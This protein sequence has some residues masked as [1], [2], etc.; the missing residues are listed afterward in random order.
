MALEEL[1]DSKDS[2]IPEVER[3]YNA[4]VHA[5]T[6]SERRQIICGLNVELQCGLCGCDQTK[7]NSMIRLKSVDIV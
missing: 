3:E 6:R 1:A 4:T 2:I 7:M 5:T